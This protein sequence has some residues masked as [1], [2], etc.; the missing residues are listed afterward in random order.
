M[1][2]KVTTQDFVKSVTMEPGW[3]KITVKEVTRESN[4]AK[5]GMNTVILW[6]I[7]NGPLNGGIDTRE[8]KQWFSDT[9][10]ANWIPLLEAIFN[11]KYTIE[12]FEEVEFDPMAFVGTV[13]WGDVQ[14]EP[15]LDQATK[16]DT[17]RLQNTIKQYMN[18]ENSPV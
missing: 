13:V 5:T 16:K 12:D 10:M 6:S 2:L 7:D 8:V 11:R 1:K 17:G 4:K 14:V 18:I 3:R 15:I 9:H